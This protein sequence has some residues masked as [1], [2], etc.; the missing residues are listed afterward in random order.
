MLKSMGIR[1]KLLWQ[2]ALQV[3]NLVVLAL[4]AIH[5]LHS[6][7]SVFHHVA[8]LNVPALKEV[9][10]ARNAQRSL[11]IITTEI[12]ATEQ[13]VPNAGKLKAD[14]EKD[15]EQ[16]NLATKAYQAMPAAEGEPALRDKVDIS[17]KEFLEVSRHMVDLASSAA[18]G[19]IAVRTGLAKKELVAARKEFR[20]SFQALADFHDEEAR[21]WAATAEESASLAT[22]YLYLAGFAGTILA[23]VAG[24]YLARSVSTTLGA[25]TRSVSEVSN[26]TSEAA[27]QVSSSS[28]QLASTSSQQASSLQET[29]ASMEEISS[30]IA[31]NSESAETTRTIAEDS[32][33]RA[34]EGQQAVAAVVSSI[35]QIQESNNRIGTQ[36]ESN[37]REMQE[38]IKIINQIETNTKVIDDIV[39]QTKLLSFNASVEAARAG[40]HGKGF[41]VVA[42]EVGNLAQMSGTA[43]KTITKIVQ[44]GIRQIQGIVQ[45]STS[46]I[47]T[48]MGESRERLKA[49]ID[50]AQRCRAILDS[51]VENVSQVSQMAEQIA[52]ASKEQSQ[53][54]REVNSAVTQ[55]DGTMQETSGAT[56]SLSGAAAAL[57]KQV[58]ILE[59]VVG[60]LSAVVYGEKGAAPESASTRGATLPAHDGESAAMTKAA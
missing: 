22:I 36:V 30:M 45:Q 11:V 60:D 29:A 48:L 31:K 57:V 59:D 55:L 53:G 56:N 28:E 39:F 40:E 49:G 9:N 54:V 7:T 24:Y 38:I 47:G 58:S 27:Q 42:E 14:F 32:R 5:Y 52:S 21:K 23:C 34:V 2:M 8:S 35:D 44:D 3:G 19:D 10:V 1:T 46:Q 12:A 33:K 15:V 6:T 26:A 51:L 41:A 17:W 43:A 4:I 18:P 20:D 37:N 25:L 50:T 13:S 16:Y